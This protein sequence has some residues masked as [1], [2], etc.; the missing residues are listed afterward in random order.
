MKMI[1]RKSKLKKNEEV[2]FEKF[3]DGSS[4]I[5][6]PRRDETIVLNETGTYIWER[7][8]RTKVKDVIKS[9]ESKIEKKHKYDSESIF[10]DCLEFLNGLLEKK[11]IIEEE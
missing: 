4:C 5:F 2:I 6:N 8:E 11:L 7:C 3:E 9:L 10:N 1:K